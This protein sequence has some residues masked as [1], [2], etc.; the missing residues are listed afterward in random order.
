MSRRKNF[1]P[2]KVSELA[3]LPSDWL[4][5]PGVQVEGMILKT[6]KL[7]VAQA[8]A[9]MC[10]CPKPACTNCGSNEEVNKAEIRWGNMYDVDR[11]GKN[12]CIVLGRQRGYCG[13]CQKPFL[14]HLSFLDRGK[15][16]RTLRFTKKGGGTL[17]R[18]RD[19]LNSRQVDW[20]EP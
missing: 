12:I 3:T 7:I 11:D 17:S 18:A 9:R 14:P 8:I 13:K 20:D 2:E 15:R 5:I 19:D 1:A 6:D 4:N 10:E 16:Q